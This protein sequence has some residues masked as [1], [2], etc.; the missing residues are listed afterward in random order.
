MAAHAA[1]AR[2]AVSDAGA[3]GLAGYLRHR[4]AYQRLMMAGFVVY[5]VRSTLL[6]LSP[7]PRFKASAR[8]DDG[9]EA[10]AGP[11]RRGKRA[12]TGG[13]ARR[14][15][16]DAEF[17]TKLGRILRIVIPSVHSRE[18]SLL[19][20][21]S[22]FLVGRTLLSLYVA[23]LDGAIVAALVRR[24]GRAFLLRII[25][26][27]AIAWPATYCNS[28]ISCKGFITLG[29]LDAPLT[30]CPIW[31]GRPPKQA[32]H[33]V[34]VAPDQ[35]GPH[36]ISRG[37]HLLRARQPRR[38]HPGR[39]SAHRGRHRKALKRPRRDLVRCTRVPGHPTGRPS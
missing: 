24:Q 37:H 13:P 31:L 7:K 28:M 32:E 18:A 9:E 5:V 2:L 25:V 29:Q 22:S 38:S 15:D 1:R 20:I 35:A 30:C 26:W 17:F 11:R 33:R 27:L 6:G 3:Q 21:H 8:A 19:L 10:G 39:R 36:Q 16:I 4:Q 34:P 12:G 14:S 23:S